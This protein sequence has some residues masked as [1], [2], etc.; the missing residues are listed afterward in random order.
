MLSFLT[1][2]PLYF[3]K[4]LSEY[5]NGITKESIRKLIEK[6]NL[7]RNKNKI[8]LPLE[9]DENDD[10]NENKKTKLYI[11]ILFLSISTITLCFYKRLK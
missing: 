3:N 8:Q 7:E 9:D 11:F 5:C 4:S 10:Y 6:N 1:K 2:R